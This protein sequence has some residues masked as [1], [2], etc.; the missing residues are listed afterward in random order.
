MKTP[1]LLVIVASLFTSLL[2]AEPSP[3]R[4]SIEQ[5]SKMEVKDKKKPH[6]KTQVRS[7]KIRLDNN[8][9]AAFDSLVVKYWFFGRSAGEHAN[10]QLVV[11]E[12]KAAL[13]ARGTE[14]VE[15]EVVSK[16]FAEESYDAKSKKKIPASGD[17]IS[18]YAV[19]VLAGDKVL[20]E[21][22]SEPSYKELIDKPG[23][24]APAPAAKPPA[25]K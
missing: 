9:T 5:S 18:G 22:L 3:V 20:A 2:H 24:A 8:S 4:M 15:S 14:T 11:G 16:S 13:N 17:K 12:R 23:A 1:I 7:L 19:R 21:T 25:K 6:D 10:K